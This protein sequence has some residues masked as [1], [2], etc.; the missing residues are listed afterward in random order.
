MIAT[1]RVIVMVS[2]ELPEV[3]SDVSRDLHFPWSNFENLNIDFKLGVDFVDRH[4]AVFFFYLG[5][6]KIVASHIKVF[7]W[8]RL[9]G[10]FRLRNEK[11]RKWLC[12]E[13][14]TASTYTI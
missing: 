14:T 6:A 13:P 2:E 4:L 10:T 8:L 11:K 12:K 9:L 7:V 1:V 3:L 5:L